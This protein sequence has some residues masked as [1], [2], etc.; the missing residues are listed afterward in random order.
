MILKPFLTI[1]IIFWDFSNQYI[2]FSASGK[3]T[4]LVV[5]PDGR[6]HEFKSSNRK[7]WINFLKIDILILLMCAHFITT[8]SRVFLWRRF[9]GLRLSW[10][11]IKWNYICASSVSFLAVFFFMKI[12]ELRRAER[13]GSCSAAISVFIIKMKCDYATFLMSCKIEHEMYRLL[14]FFSLQYVI[15]SYLESAIY[16]FYFVEKI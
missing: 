9:L 10:K 13:L 16:Q 2:Y 1:L 11:R 7:S 15:V 12:A 14:H 8:M 4:F 3:K 5:H 6:S